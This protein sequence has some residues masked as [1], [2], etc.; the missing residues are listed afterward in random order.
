MSALARLGSVPL[1]ENE[2]LAFFERRLRLGTAVLA[3]G[4]GASWAL[5]IGYVALTAPESATDVAQTPAAFAELAGLVVLGSAWAWLRRGRPT[6]RALAAAESTL[7]VA[8]G[9][10]LSVL[11]LPFASERHDRAR[12]SVSRSSSRCAPPSFLAHRDAPR[13]SARSRAPRAC[14]RG[15]R[16][17][18]A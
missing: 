16:A 3:C 9:V 10:L 1:D 6:L 4:W 14:T 17:R 12:G 8:Q 2:A 18:A 15:S 13:S 11:L 7:T 5:G